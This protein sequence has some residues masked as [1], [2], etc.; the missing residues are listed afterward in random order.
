MSVT[1]AQ[2]GVEEYELAPEHQSVIIVEPA[3]PAE[4]LPVPVG[5]LWAPEADRHAWR[6][7]TR[8]GALIILA[9]V[10]LIVARAL[11]WVDSEAAD[12]AATLGI[13]VGALAIAIDGENADA[14]QSKPR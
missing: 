11:N 12:I 5:R 14:P 3:P 10:A 8:I 6:V 9:G 7:T 2:M 4:I 13:V 1:G